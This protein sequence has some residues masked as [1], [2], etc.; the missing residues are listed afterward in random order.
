MVL[1]TGLLPRPVDGPSNTFGHRYLE[2][3]NID[4]QAAEKLAQ[5]L[6]Q[7]LGYI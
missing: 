1:R 6:H 7:P 2:Y 3:Q 4:Q 5:L